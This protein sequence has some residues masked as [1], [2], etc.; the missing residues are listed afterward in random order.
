MKS[1]ITRPS[2][3]SSLSLEGDMGTWNSEFLAKGILE[4]LTWL[5]IS[6]A[7]L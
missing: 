4:A 1:V 7:V 2:W 5:C 3:K 6:R